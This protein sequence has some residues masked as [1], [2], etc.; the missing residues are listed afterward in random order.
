MLANPSRGVIDGDLVA[1]FL[2]L[3]IPEKQEVCKKIGTKIEEIIDDLNE[4]DQITS[5]F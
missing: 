5:N 1:T 3:S 4:I 2:F